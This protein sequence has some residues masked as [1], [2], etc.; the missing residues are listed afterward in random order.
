M[1]WKLGLREKMRAEGEEKKGEEGRDWVHAVCVLFS[2]LLSLSLSSLP[3]PL[4]KQCFTVPDGHQIPFSLILDLSF[5]FSF[6]ST[7]IIQLALSACSRSPSTKHALISLSLLLIFPRR[8]TLSQHGEQIT[9]KLLNMGSCLCKGHQGQS[10]PDCIWVC[11]SLSVLRP[12]TYLLVHPVFTLICL[13]T[14]LLILSIYIMR[15]CA[16]N[17][18]LFKYNAKLTHRVVSDWNK[19]SLYE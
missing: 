18:S 17:H 10:L 12:S 4:E 14:C 11:L 9:A 13:S 5:S 16:E 15:E 2:P 19:C 6:F 3:S 8:P 7:S 1:M